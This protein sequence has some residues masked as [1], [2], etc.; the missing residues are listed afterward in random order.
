MRLTGLA[1]GF[2]VVAHLP[3]GTAEQDVIRAAQARSVALYGMSTCRA[4]HSPHPPR[5][6]LGF[7]DTSQRA[8]QE[9]ITLVGDLL[10]NSH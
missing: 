9:G 7:G 4:D 2:H 5:L 1:A 6:V 8:I 3:A 10:Q